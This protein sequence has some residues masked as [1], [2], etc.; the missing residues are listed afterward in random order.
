MDWFAETRQKVR[1]FETEVEH[2]HPVFCRLA[3]IEY[4]IWRIRQE[5]NLLLNDIDHFSKMRKIVNDEELPI[6]IEPTVQDAV[7]RIRAIKYLEEQLDYLRFEPH[8]H[9]RSRRLKPEDVE[10]ARAYPLENLVKINR[11]HMALCP[12]HFD[13]KPSLYCKGNF[14]YCFV[15]GFKGDSIKVYSFL[16]KT[17]FAESVRRLNAA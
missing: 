7:K 9:Y 6:W 13:H 15:C 10:R 17:S 16:N 12:A 1:L 3:K 14:A 5:E 4:T 2:E 8:Q 11:R